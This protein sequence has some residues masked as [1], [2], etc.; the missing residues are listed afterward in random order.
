MYIVKEE[1]LG[2]AKER[3]L[4]LDRDSKITLFI[5]TYM[6]KVLQWKT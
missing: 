2:Y 5:V 4:K 3:V 1:L 6:K